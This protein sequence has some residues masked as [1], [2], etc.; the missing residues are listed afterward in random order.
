MQEELP[1]EFCDVCNGMRKRGDMV[2][3][4]CDGKGKCKPWDAKYPFDTENVREFVTFLKGSGGF[5]IW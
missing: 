3:N 2:C 4:M 5:V 1:E